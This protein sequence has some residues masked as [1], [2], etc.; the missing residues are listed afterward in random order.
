[1]SDKLPDIIPL[2]PYY[3]EMVWGGRRLH[4]LYGKAL[5]P[6]VAIGPVGI[7]TQFE[8]Q[9]DRLELMDG[10]HEEGRVGDQLGIFLLI[11]DFA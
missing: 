5:P 10:A 4:A 9:F 3:R 2:E 11:L 7:R 6:A 1:M 8:E